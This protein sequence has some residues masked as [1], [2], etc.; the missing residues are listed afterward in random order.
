MWSIEN[1]ASCIEAG[2]VREASRLELEQ[3]VYGLD[4]RGEAPLQLQIAEA[5]QAAGHG[6][7]R[8][9]RYPAYRSCRRESE[10]ERCDLVLTPNA[11]PLAAPER[12]PTLFDPTDA[13][14]LADAYWM[15]IKVVAQFT[16]RGPNPRYSSLFGPVRRDITKLSKQPGILHAGL[17]IVLF[18]ED[19]KVADHDLR[20]WTSQCKEHGHR[21]G[22]PELRSVAVNDRLGNNFCRLALFPVQ[23]PKPARVQGDVG[24]HLVNISSPHSRSGNRR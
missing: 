9:Q 18:V 16:T 17:L 11:R 4:S 3:A 23:P 14:A 6:V 5:L 2:L 15:E 20:V 12:N 1:I 8:E 19:K 21:I 24:A 7:Y 13:V 10:G 22:R